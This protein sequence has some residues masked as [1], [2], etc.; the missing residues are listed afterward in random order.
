MIY[1]KKVKLKKKKSKKFKFLLSIFCI[2]GIFLL[3]NLYF[4]T[5]VN[6]II[7]SLSEVN[8]QNLALKAANSAVSEVLNGASMYNEL[9]EIV[10]DEEGNVKSVLTNSVAINKLSY[11]LLESGQNKLEIIGETGI[12]IPIGNFTG[13][14]LFSGRGPSVNIKVLPVGSMYAEFLSKFRSAGINQTSHQI[15]VKLTSVVSLILPTF[16][17]DITTV[18]ELIICEGIIVGKVPEV[19]LSSNKIGDLLNL[20]P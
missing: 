3:L 19:Y 2:I 18:N 15:I 8:V 1:A 6:P 17:K 11:K 16:S 10:H 9:V 4:V 12:P 7:V 14:P 13:I 20:V 5:Y